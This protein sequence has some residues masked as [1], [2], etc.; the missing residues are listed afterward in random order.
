L[1]NDI[2]RE[3]PEDA[4]IL[5][6]KIVGNRECLRDNGYVLA[7]GLW[8]P[9]ITGIA[10]PIWSPQYQTYVV[11]TIGLLAAMYDEQRLRDEIAPIL[12]QL[13]STISMMVQNADS[14]LTSAPVPDAPPAPTTQKKILPEGINELEAG[15]RRP[16][17]A[18]SLRAGDGG[19]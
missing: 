3:M 9:H 19:R 16:R 7:G 6:D 18:R 11:V 1:I 5:R 12:R 4:K 15:T 13:S 14:G 8:S 17:P 10:T 2:A